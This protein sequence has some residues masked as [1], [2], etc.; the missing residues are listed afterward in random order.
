[1]FGLHKETLPVTAYFAMKNVS[2]LKSL[3]GGR[4]VPK[5][6]ALSVHKAPFMRSSSVPGNS[7]L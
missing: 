3:E 1:M 2:E 5:T 4:T 7:A 6:E